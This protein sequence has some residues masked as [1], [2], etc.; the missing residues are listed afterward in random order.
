MPS[1][2]MSNCRVGANGVGLL[3]VLKV[4]ARESDDAVESV[5]VLQVEIHQCCVGGLYKELQLS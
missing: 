1:Q 2:S 4:L 3:G 5:V